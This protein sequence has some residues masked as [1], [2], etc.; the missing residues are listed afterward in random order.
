MKHL[1]ALAI[2]FGFVSIVLLST[3]SLFEVPIYIILLTTLILIIPAYVLGDL[4]L[5]P[6][7]GNLIASIGDFVYYTLAVWVFMHWF[8]ITYNAV[9]GMNAMLTAIFIT[10]LEALYHEFYIAKFTEKQERSSG[11]KPQFK[12]EFAEENDVKSEMNKKKK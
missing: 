4:F 5:Y 2:K 8:I 12:T 3:L 7:Y 6:K 10:F 1:K 11:F 9:N